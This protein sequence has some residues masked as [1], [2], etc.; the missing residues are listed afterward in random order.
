[1][2]DIYCYYCDVHG[3]EEGS[4]ECKKHWTYVEAP[5]RERMRAMVGKVFKTADPAPVLYTDDNEPWDTPSGI[6]VRL[7][8]WTPDTPGMK[9]GD[10]WSIRTLDGK[11]S[12]TQI[13][14]DE[15]EELSALDRMSLLE[16]EPMG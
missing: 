2:T 13:Y 9:A 6:F 10:Y 12:A 16:E 11:Y 3:H 8:H 7:T 15:L 14:Q 1:M 5:Y 4:E